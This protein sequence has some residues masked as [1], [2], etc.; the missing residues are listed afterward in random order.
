M[1]HVQS[2]APWWLTAT[3]AILVM[4]LTLHWNWTLKV[5]PYGEWQVRQSNRSYIASSHLLYAAADWQ[6]DRK[7]KTSTASLVNY[8]TTWPR[9]EKRVKLRCRPEN[10]MF[11]WMSQTAIMTSIRLLFDRCSTSSIGIATYKLWFRYVVS[12][13]TVVFLRRTSKII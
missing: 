2:N 11:V 10:E 5:T 9:R 12:I 3:I 1:R 7:R 6:G 8:A 13:I 4:V